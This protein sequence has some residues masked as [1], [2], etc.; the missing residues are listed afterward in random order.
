MSNCTEHRPS[1][2]RDIALVLAVKA[3]LLFI[4]LKLVAPPMPVMDGIEAHMLG[5]QPTSGTATLRATE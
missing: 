5:L 4:I 1:L 3:A 2:T